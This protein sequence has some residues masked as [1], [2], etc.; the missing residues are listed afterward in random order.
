[1]F[2]GRA[3]AF[4]FSKRSAAW[5]R[6]EAHVKMNDRSNQHRPK[7]RNFLWAGVHVLT[8][9]VAHLTEGPLIRNAASL[10]GSTIVTSVL[11][12]CYWLLAA[13]MVPATAVGTASAI[14]SGAQF[15]S[16]FCVL[17]LGT[18]LISELSVDRTHARSL[19]L[20]AA[21]SA[22]TLALLVSVGVGVSLANATNS[23]SPGLS[24]P[25][26]ILI[27][28]IITMLS[29][30]LLLMD[31]VCIGLLRGDLQL[32]RNTVFAVSKLMILPLLIA[33]W[34]ERTG[35]EL[36]L[37]WTVGLALS[38]VTVSIAVKNLFPKEQW[39]LDFS[40]LYAKRKLIF[41]HHWLNLSAQSPRL[42]IP[43]LCAAIVGAAANAAYTAATLIAYFV[44]VIPLQLSTVLF[45]LAPGDEV[46]LKRE[47]RRTMRL[48]GWIALAAAPFFA[49]FGSRILAL[50]GHSY[51]TASTA[52]T[53]LGLTTYP[54]AIK[55]HYIAIA[56]VRGKMNQAAFRTTV[57]STLEVGLAAAGGALHGVTGVAI[58][59]LAG[60]LLEGLFFAPEV[61][62]AMRKNR[63]PNTE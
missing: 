43:V 38:M 16:I 32:R 53:V 52:L 19:I 35:E 25:I 49:L 8:D 17:G 12:F 24:N 54:F 44:T 31:D 45:A 50:F 18:L 15:L 46:A 40:G 5:R 48:S 26:K 34:P 2:R 4:D 63:L 37:V 60:S 55:A 28:A 9:E 6:H 62:S 33:L 51:Q 42:L 22:G 58:G 11:G 23:L 10:Y 39:H 41:G 21:V 57:G 27:F 61:F 56:R 30:V 29:T 14:Q 3:L 36:V 47:V 1:M 7:S 20:T 59:F 13:H